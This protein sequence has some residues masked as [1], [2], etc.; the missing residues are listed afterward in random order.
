M[1]ATKVSFVML[2]RWLLDP[3]LRMR[4]DCQWDQLCDW[5]VGTFSPTT[6]HLQGWERGWRLNQSPT[7]N[8]LIHLTFVNEATI[9]TRKDGFWRASG[10][11]LGE[12]GVLWKDM[13][14]THSLW[15]D[16]VRIE[17]NCR[18]LSWYRGKCLVVWGK[19]HPRLELVPE[20]L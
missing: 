16:S 14:A 6:P 17:L 19:W 13:E 18:T 9:K 10:W 7:A 15:V 2:I 8:D 4:A 11:Q 5:R 1:R 12:S 3:H 20:P